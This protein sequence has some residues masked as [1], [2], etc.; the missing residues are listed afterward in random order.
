[1]IGSFL[2]K[3]QISVKLVPAG[4]METTI[5]IVG[6]CIFIIRYAKNMLRSILPWK[7]FPLSVFCFWLRIVRVFCLWLYLLKDAVTAEINVNSN[8]SIEGAV[9]PSTQCLPEAKFLPCVLW[10]FSVV[11]LTSRWRKGEIRTLFKKHG[12]KKAFTIEHHQNP[13]KRT[14][15]PTFV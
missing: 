14:L 2:Y 15:L 8:Q 6:A 1:M 4:G 9:S 5:L 12:C 13:L 10:M 7:I 11:R 3:N